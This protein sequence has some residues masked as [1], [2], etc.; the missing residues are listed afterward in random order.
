M[1]F[2]WNLNT[3]TVNTYCYYNNIF[4]NDDLDKIVNDGK[5]LNL[6]YAAVGGED[7]VEVSNNSM[8][9]TKI[10]WFDKMDYEWIYRRLTD[11]ILEANKE[12]FQYD[13]DHIEAL[14]FTLYDEGDFYTKHVDHMYK[15]FG[16]DPRKLSFV[17]QL[18]DPSEYEG[19]KTLL[20]ISDEPFAIPQ[21][22][23]CITFFPSYILHEVTKVTKG[24][25]ISLVGWVRGSKFK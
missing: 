1:S 10:S 22:R 13:L 18:T 8:R 11:I 9:S 5:K 6:S 15:G 20:H 14:Q 23:G 3:H 4:S 17:L 2:T 12:W 7:G 19:G 24:Q 21:D 25:R 16:T